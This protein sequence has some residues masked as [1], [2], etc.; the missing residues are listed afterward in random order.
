MRDPVKWKHY[1]CRYYHA[2][3]DKIRA[4]RKER[5]KL[6]AESRNFGREFEWHLKRKYGLSVEQYEAIWQ[7]QQGRCANTECNRELI[8]GKSAV[9]HCHT[10]KH[11]RG[12][13]CSNC[14]L[15]IG[16][17]GDSS[18]KARGLAVYL[19]RNLNGNTTPN[20]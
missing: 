12:I 5:Y 11:V 17:I 8:R 2:N 9:D 10:S 18:H 4:R 3:R 19:D 14:N 16:L 20:V 1:Q 13:L 15:A 6:K 7:Q